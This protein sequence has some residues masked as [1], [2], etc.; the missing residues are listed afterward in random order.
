VEKPFPVLRWVWL[1]FFAVWVPTY[2]IYWSPADFLYLCNLAVILTFAGLWLDNRLLLSSQA[3]STVVIGTLWA[4]DVAW[5]ASAHGRAPIGGTEYM[6]NAS[7]PLWLRLLSFDH[8]A[9]PATTLWVIWKTGYDRRAWAFQSGL[10][11]MV[12]VASR[13]VAPGLNL[14]FAQKELVTY[15]TWGPAP[16]H[17]LVIWSV[18]VLV[19][20]W[21]VH[22]V[23][24]GL[25]AGP[26]A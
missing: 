24:C 7:Y 9:V 25:K 11:A 10:A 4:L 16:V 19:V 8:L 3:V 20:Y 6:W 26:P 12:L 13:V 15:H 17:L 14:N 1:A 21:P 22:A 18:L 5:G 23:L 2:W